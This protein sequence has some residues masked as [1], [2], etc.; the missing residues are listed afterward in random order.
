MRWRG[1][2][3]RWRA[4]ALA[5]GGGGGGGAAPRWRSA[6]GRPA[7][8]VAAPLL[9]TQHA[10]GRWRRGGA[11]LRCCAPSFLRRRPHASPHP[12]HH[13]RRGASS[14]PPPRHLCA[15]SAR[16]ADAFRRP[17]KCARMRWPCV[18]R[19][20]ALARQQRRV[21]APHPRPHPCPSVV[22]THASTLHLLPPPGSRRRRCC[23]RCWACSGGRPSPRRRRRAFTT[24]F[25]HAEEVPRPAARFSHPQL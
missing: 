14:S 20:A 13:R 5:C 4:E 11:A 10:L 21:T 22:C 6:A 15:A 7:A 17:S 24:P 12:P 9:G 16:H 23:G 2:F 1:S 25:Q 19:A 8:G 18:R 3:A